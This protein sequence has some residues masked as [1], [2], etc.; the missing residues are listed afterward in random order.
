MGP[1]KF[2]AISTFNLSGLKLYGERMIKTFQQNW[3]NDVQLRIYSENWEGDID[4]LSVSP[5]LAR[6]KDRNKG[7]Q[8]KDYRWDAIRFSHKVAAVCHAAR[9]DIDILIWLDG[10][11]ITHSPIKVEDLVA[12]AP[13]G[14]EWISWLDREK[15]Y[16]ECGFYM[17]NC[18][19]PRHKAMIDSFQAQYDDDLLF[20]LAEWHDC[21][22]LAHI[23][24]STGIKT[25]SLSGA[26]AQTNHPLINGPLGAWLDHA[27]GKRKTLGRSSKGEL[28][29]K[30][31][32][33][34][35]C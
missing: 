3:P 21:Y 15:V 28:K 10:D 9:E 35:W 17:L 32:E 22:V 5:W 7:R 6:F 31:S 4:L 13:S 14:E 11:I 12:L 19:H 20:A 27:K 8:F 23:V 33:P 29:V 16:P 26:G 34:H 25:K 18:R 30:R 1:L 2:L 24:K